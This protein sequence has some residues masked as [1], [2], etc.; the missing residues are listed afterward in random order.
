MAKRKSPSSPRPDDDRTTDP[1]KVLDWSGAALRP[2]E[3]ESLLHL[4]ALSPSVCH[5]V[6]R[7]CHL[8]DACCAVLARAFSIENEHHNTSVQVLDVRENAIGTDGAR[9]LL[10]VL[11][12]GSPTLLRIRV[13]GN[14]SL[15][16][17]ARR[18][19]VTAADEKHLVAASPM[20]AWGTDPRRLDEEMGFLFLASLAH[21]RRDLSAGTGLFPG[22]VHV[23]AEG[24]TTETYV[25]ASVRHSFGGPVR[26]YVAALHPVLKDDYEEERECFY[27]HM[28]LVV[29]RHTQFSV[30]DPLGA[31]KHDAWWVAPLCRWMARHGGC[32]SDAAP[33]DAYVGYEPGTEH[34]VQ[35]P[36][37]WCTLWTYWYAHRLLFPHTAAAAVLQELPCAYL[38]RQT[39]VRYLQIFYEQYEAFRLDACRNMGAGS[40]SLYHQRTAIAREIQALYVQASR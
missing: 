19:F 10:H 35:G 30:M 13:E 26:L 37:G 12:D 40:A 5:L 3:L 24:C 2:A 8:D 39:L 34:G 1:E 38:Y 21:H 29:A 27:S 23:R 9:R 7:R 32:A 28:V 17:K 16:R 36:E 33:I 6:L 14:S 25:P 22:V 31:T 4:L 18:A 15:P 20:A 11:M